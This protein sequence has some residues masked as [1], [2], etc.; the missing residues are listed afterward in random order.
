MPLYV[1]EVE[2]LVGFVDGLKKSASYAHAMAHYQANPNWLK[3]RDMLENLIVHGQKMA[4]SKSVPRDEVIKQLD[5]R[6]SQIKT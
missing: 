4:M 1:S 3:V 2:A 5:Y 6:Q